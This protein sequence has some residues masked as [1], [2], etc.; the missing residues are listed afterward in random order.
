MDQN[1][2]GFLIGL[3]GA[4]ITLSAYTQTLVSTTQCI[5]IGFLVLMFG[6]LVKEGFIS[7]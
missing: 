5:V 3:V 7:L 1:W 4:A 2:S 6:L